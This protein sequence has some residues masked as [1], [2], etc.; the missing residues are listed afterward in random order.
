MRWDG[1]TLGRIKGDTLVYAGTDDTYQ[2]AGGEAGSQSGLYFHD[3]DDS[4]AWNGG[5]DIF[6]ENSDPEPGS[7]TADPQLHSTGYHITA[8]TSPAIGAGSAG[9]GDIPDANGWDRSAAPPAWAPTSGPPRPSPQATR[10]S[11]GST[12][13]R[14]AIRPWSMSTTAAAA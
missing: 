5:E 9:Y 13:V 1:P 2:I 7:I 11:V 12:G 8:E 10:P 3:A 6:V 4:G 14:W